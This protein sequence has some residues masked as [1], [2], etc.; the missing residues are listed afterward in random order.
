M[1][2]AILGFLADHVYAVALVATAVDGTGLP[3]PGRLIVVMAGAMASSSEA[4]SV[5]ALVGVAAAGAVLGD[6]VWYVLGRWGGDRPIEL[7]CRFSLGSGQCVRKTG[8]YYRKFGPATIVIGRFV[9]GVRIFAS[10]LAGAGLV[11]YWKFLAFEV[12]GA[13]LWAGLFVGAGYLL[14][15]RAVR[16]LEGSTWVPLAGGLAAVL[17]LAAPVGQRLWRRARHG[18]AAV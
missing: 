1:V 15:G 2:Q 11:P 7:Y 9:A 13:L 4:V 10:P 17:A 6:H 8:E 12:A 14:G 18:P 3:F 5:L 16:F